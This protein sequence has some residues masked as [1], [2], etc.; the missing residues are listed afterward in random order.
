M[1][2]RRTAGVALALAGCAWA[3]DSWLSKPF[4]DW[5]DKDAQR[6]IAGS[7][8]SRQVSVMPSGATVP[9]HSGDR[10]GTTLDDNPTTMRV[11]TNAENAEVVAKPRE[12]Q[13][14]D[15]AWQPAS[16]P[17]K[18]TIQWRSA[19]PVRQALARSK[20]G[21]EAATSAEAK[22]FLETEPSGYVIA[23]IGIPKA[24][25]HGDGETLKKMLTDRAA[26]SAG[27]RAPIHPD[28]IQFRAAA[29]VDVFFAFPKASVFTVDDKD[30][31]F[32]VRIDPLTIKEK[33][34]LRDMMF[35]GKLEL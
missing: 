12:S 32:A 9:S 16:G 28:E 34:R 5:T 18:L 19:L 22:R 1:I 7:P 3:A 8:W 2:A 31:E 35:Q 27:G 25:L 33:F 29:A 15:E 4:A 20:Y 11:P 13:A 21:A 17:V 10:R 23:V 30:I 24:F 14:G 26:I 6:I